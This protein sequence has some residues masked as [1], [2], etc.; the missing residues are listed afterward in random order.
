MCFWWCAGTNLAQVEDVAR[1][2]L[3]LGLPYP[4]NMRP[5]DTQRPPPGF[6]VVDDGTGVVFAESDS[7]LVQNGWRRLP[8]SMNCF[9]RQSPEFWNPCPQVF[10]GGVEAPRLRDGIEYAEVRGCVRAAPGGPLPTGAVVGQIR[11]DQRIQ[12]PVRPMPP[13]DQQ[14]LRQKRRR[15]H[16]DP[17]VHPAGSP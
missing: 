7:G 13:V 14:M 1:V 17:V 2:F 5:I 4:P 9:A 11:I 16:A 6:G 8:R 3:V 12:E 10:P 15:N